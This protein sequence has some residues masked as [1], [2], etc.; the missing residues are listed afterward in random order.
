MD[1]DTRKNISYVLGGI[2]VLSL[3]MFCCFYSRIKLAIA[4]L[5][6]GSMYLGSVWTSILV[7]IFLVIP[8]AI[9]LVVYLAGFVVVYTGQYGEK[10]NLTYTNGYVQVGLIEENQK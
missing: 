1:P 5:K 9:F 7:P 8:Y 10:T 2:F 3:L 6:T 4:I